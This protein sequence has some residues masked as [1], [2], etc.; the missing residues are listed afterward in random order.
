MARS[1]ISG[2]VK[3]ALDELAALPADAVREIVIEMRRGTGLPLEGHATLGVAVGHRGETSATAGA[4]IAE[5]PTVLRVVL[6][7][8]NALPPGPRDVFWAVV[9]GATYDGIKEALRF[10]IQQVAPL[11]AAAHVSGAEPVREDLRHYVP[12]PA[13]EQHEPAPPVA[14]PPLGPVADFTKT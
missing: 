5:R 1:E 11:I 10:G 2:A 13:V 9:G 3:A 14:A 12:P 4:F 6:D 7:S 8:I